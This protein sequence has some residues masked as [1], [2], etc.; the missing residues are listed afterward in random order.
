MLPILV[1]CNALTPIGA[2]RN[3]MHSDDASIRD[4]FTK[5]RPELDWLPYPN[6]NQDNL[7]GAIDET[8]PKGEPGVGV[9]DNRHVGGFAAL[10]YAA[11]NSLFAFYLEA[12]IYAQVTRGAKGPL[13]GIA[14]RIDTVSGNFYRLATQFMGAEPALSLAYWERKR[15]TFRNILGAGAE[16]KFL[17]APRRAADGKRSLL[18]FRKPKLRPIGMERTFP[19]GLFR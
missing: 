3:T 19:A 8:S 15:T 4:S 6:F 2:K 10:S 18:P 7:Q 12:W 5:G 14:F 11:T 17:A 13:N 9:L 1:S 16:K